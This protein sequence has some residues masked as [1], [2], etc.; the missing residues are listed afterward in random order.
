MKIIIYERLPWEWNTV[1][2]IKSVADK[3]PLLKFFDIMGWY[4]NWLSVIK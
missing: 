2:K 3:A 4:S 1:I